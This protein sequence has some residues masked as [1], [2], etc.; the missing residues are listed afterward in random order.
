MADRDSLETGGEDGDRETE[1]HAEH[2]DREKQPVKIADMIVVEGEDGNRSAVKE[3][4][5]ENALPIE[6]GGV[7]GE[8]KPIEINNYMD[9]EDEKEEKY[10]YE[11]KKEEPP[12]P[13][14]EPSTTDAARDE[15]E[16]PPPS[17]REV[18][19]GETEG[20][21]LDEE[22][23]EKDKEAREEQEEQLPPLV[24]GQVR[25][26]VRNP[27]SGFV[28]EEQQ[29]QEQ[30]PVRVK[31][32]DNQG[33]TQNGDESQRPRKRRRRKDA[34]TKEIPPGDELLD[35]REVS[36]QARDMNS[37][38]V[39]SL[40]QG[41]YRDAHTVPNCLFCKVCI[42]QY[43][44]TGNS[45]CPV[46][47]ADLGPHPMKI[48]LHDRTLQ[49][50]VDKIFPVSG[51]PPRAPPDDPLGGQKPSLLT[52][53]PPALAVVP[54]EADAKIN[55]KVEPDA[56]QEPSHVL[57]PLP[58][59]YLR[60]PGTLKIAD[61]RRYLSKKLRIPNDATFKILSKGSSLSA[62]HSIHFRICL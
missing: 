6:I 50:S 14:R 19:G 1:K 58:K 59:P 62:E 13:D 21:R 30:Q 4:R 51:E 56:D 54:S 35:F 47:L 40:C 5:E 22:P 7:D 10:A 27:R 25:V 24:A 61:L 53:L 43:L 20:R 41:Y 8:T 36:F 46:C 16:E 33:E 42:L 38:L 44:T 39:C 55:F 23:T 17:D 29:Q 34:V 48:I 31:N 2:I 45:T 18:S 37:H 3:Q 12:P 32:E 15:K 26:V 9:D 52:N 60:T 49:M 11:E 57:G 28:T